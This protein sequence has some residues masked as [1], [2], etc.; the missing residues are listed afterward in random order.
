MSLK[1][2]TLS[3]RQIERLAVFLSLTENVESVTI[4]ET[5][6]S[7]IG[8]SHWVVYHSTKSERDWQEEITDVG[9]W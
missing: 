3:R 9:N 2:V 5:H 4:E 6:E 1:K 8:A 7:G